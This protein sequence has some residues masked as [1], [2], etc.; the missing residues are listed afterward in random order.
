MSY[1]LTLQ[2]HSRFAPAFAQFGG[3]HILAWTD[4]DGSL[5]TVRLAGTIEEILNP[6]P[7]KVGFEP[8]PHAPT[9]LEQE[10]SIGQP[11]LAEFNGRL[12]MAWTGTDGAG[13][14][15]VMSSADGR[16]WDP[17]SKRILPELSMAGPTLA[18]YAGRLYIAWTG[19]DGDG[20][21]SLM[22]SMDGETF[23]LVSRDLGQHSIDGSP[24]LASGNDINQQ[25]EFLFIG[26]TERG[27]NKV[28]F[29]TLFQNEQYV[30]Q[31][32][33]AGLVFKNQGQQDI[34]SVVPFA[35]STAP[36]G[37]LA[38]WWIDGGQ[39]ICKST[40]DITAV[41]EGVA[42]WD[43]PQVFEDT[44]DHP[45]AVVRGTFEIAWRGLDG[46]H[47]LNIAVAEPGQMPTV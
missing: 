18:A 33:G 8:A 46:E 1:K 24:S 45:P 39:H 26:W 37:A 22:A 21:L 10:S 6:V 36:F 2:L 41:V 38:A 47:R 23:N 13:H 16:T 28:H 3:H 12:Y 34:V 44:T 40:L 35:L 9:G 42:L 27:T 31:F 11:A 4:D 32:G 30:A 5:N 17:A 29:G 20:T 7:I 14:L 19:V 15:N 43:P 25:N